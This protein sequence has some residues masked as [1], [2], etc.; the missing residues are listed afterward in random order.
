MITD[1]PIK[2][3]EDDAIGRVY[4]ARSFARQVLD[5]DASSGIVVGVLGAWGS[6]KTSFINLARPEFKHA[7]VEVID[8]NPWMFSGV[9]QLM[10]HFFAEMSAQLKVRPGLDQVGKSIEEYGEAFSSLAWIPYIGLGS[11]VSG[12][13]PRC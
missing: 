10:E 12:P 1:N 2:R 7:G 13:R 9:E 3:V 5:L 11:K 6:G 4:S 8:F